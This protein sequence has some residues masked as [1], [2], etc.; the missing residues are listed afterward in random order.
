[1]KGYTSDDNGGEMITSADF[2]KDSIASKKKKDVRFTLHY[3]DGKMVLPSEEVDNDPPSEEEEDDGGGGDSDDDDGDGSESDDDSDGSGL[4]DECD[5]D[6]INNEYASDL[7]S[8]DPEDEENEMVAREAN[9]KGNN[10]RGPSEELPYT[11]TGNRG[12][13]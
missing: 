6:Q 11:F 2:M 9:R 3:E 13:R 7:D 8:E 10:S 12:E 4:D 5:S 1:M